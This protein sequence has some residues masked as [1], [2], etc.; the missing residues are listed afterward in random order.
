MWTW[1]LTF[2]LSCFWPVSLILHLKEAAGPSPRTRACAVE[3][4]LAARIVT[5]WMQSLAQ[6]AGSP[7]DT[8]RGEYRINCGRGRRVV[9]VHSATGVFSGKSACVRVCVSELCHVAAQGGW[10]SFSSEGRSSGSR[11]SRILSS[12]VDDV[13]AWLCRGSE[14]PKLRLRQQHHRCIK[15]GL[16]LRFIWC[17]VVLHTSRVNG[18]GL[19]HLGLPFPFWYIAIHLMVCLEQMQIYNHRRK[20]TLIYFFYQAAHGVALRRA[21]MSRFDLG[22]QT[23]SAVRYVYLHKYQI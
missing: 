20:K 14:V 15:V 3:L 7:S 5:E 13:S 19:H 12:R 23:E 10:A 17:S 4:P 22:F 6:D 1:K 16:C 8:A 18:T 21:R 2:P 9:V 11:K